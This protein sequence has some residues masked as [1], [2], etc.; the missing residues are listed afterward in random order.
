[1]LLS[2]Q[3]MRSALKSVIFLSRELVLLASARSVGKTVEFAGRE[4]EIQF[5]PECLE[6]MSPGSWRRAVKE[7]PP[8][9]V[10]RMRSR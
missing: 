7:P 6:V 10:M 4:I 8:E 2:L 9:A 3:M 1:M 5:G